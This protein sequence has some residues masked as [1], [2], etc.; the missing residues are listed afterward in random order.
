VRLE[1]TWFE[2]A[3]TSWAQYS[4]AGEFSNG[5]GEVAAASQIDVGTAGELELAKE[6]CYKLT[7]THL[8]TGTQTVVED[9][10]PASKIALPNISRELARTRSKL[11]GA[12]EIPPENFQVEWCEAL[13]NPEKTS[14]CP[15]GAKRE[16]CT[17]A[18]STCSSYAEL[19]CSMSGAPRAL[20]SSL[21]S[22]ALG[23]SS[24]VALALS[25]SWRRRAKRAGLGGVRPATPH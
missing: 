16:A 19:A 12:C 21:G 2:V 8:A 7:V 13:G 6:Y 15:E 4:I 24:M 25:A 9:C 1:T 18:V 14:D 23:V 3:Q 22:A 10:L 20:A 17:R 11:M 5:Q